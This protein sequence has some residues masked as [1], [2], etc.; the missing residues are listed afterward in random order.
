VH[1]L[2][3]TVTYVSSLSMDRRI[4]PARDPLKVTS[5]AYSV[6][7]KPAVLDLLVALS[8]IFAVLMTF[9]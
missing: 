4:L 8:A 9:R 3:A 5:K 1:A 6:S 7:Q 2:L